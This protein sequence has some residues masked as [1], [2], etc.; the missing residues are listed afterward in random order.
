[1]KFPSLEKRKKKE[2]LCLLFRQVFR[3]EA[4]YSAV[5]FP[6]KLPQNLL[7]RPEVTTLLSVVNVIMHPTHN[8]AQA[9]ALHCLAFQANTAIPHQKRETQKKPGLSCLGGTL[10]IPARLSLRCRTEMTGKLLA[11]W[12]RSLL[13]FA[14]PLYS[15]IALYCENTLWT[16]YFY[17]LRKKS[18]LR[19]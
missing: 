17:D 11:I 19:D 5:N 7:L 9:F 6:K 4:S 8:L 10:H 15:F 12:A 13:V 2:C 1:M 16:L 18:F 3:N 14:K